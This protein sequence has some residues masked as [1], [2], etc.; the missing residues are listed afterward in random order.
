MLTAAPL[1]G[2]KTELAAEELW[3]LQSQE[4]WWG[5]SAFRMGGVAV[6]VGERSPRE[7]QQELWGPVSSAQEGTEM[8]RELEVV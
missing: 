6:S 5:C 8:C 3:R 4:P 7:C 1:G 2:V